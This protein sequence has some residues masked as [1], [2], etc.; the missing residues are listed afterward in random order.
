MAFF[1]TW[2]IHPNFQWLPVHHPEGIIQLL[3]TLLALPRVLLLK[4]Q[5]VIFQNALN[6]NNR[7]H[8]VL[9]KHNSRL[10]DILSELF[11]IF[12]IE[13]LL[14]GGL[15]AATV[16]STLPSTEK[17]RLY[18]VVAAL[19]EGLEDKSPLMKDARW[20]L[21]L[22]DINNGD[23][24]WKTM[25]EAWLG[26]IKQAFADGAAAAD[27]DLVAGDAGAGAGGAGDGIGDNALETRGPLSADERESA[28]CLLYALHGGS[29]ELL[30]A[31]EKGA[32]P[33]YLLQQSVGELVKW[34]TR[35]YSLGVVK[36]AM[37]ILFKLPWSW[38]VPV[39]VARV[40]RLQC[41]E[42]EK[43]WQLERLLSGWDPYTKTRIEGI[44]EEG[45]KHLDS[46]A[47]VIVAAV[48]RGDKEQVRQ[49]EGDPLFSILLKLSQ[50]ALTRI[51]KEVL[52]P[53]A[54]DKYKHN[55]SDNW[56]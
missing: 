52:I 10:V 4:H 36:T 32:L 25:N 27:T 49:G 11:H 40:T 23:E 14:L 12:P 6:E 55:G 1:E 9:L 7:G 48:L 16:P 41:D 15:Q 22:L 37:K 51:I 35:S 34:V 13:Q 42:G 31:F 19:L 47:D 53:A 26:L 50:S 54:T 21:F 28:G 20:L 5:P 43:V 44:E 8:L 46:H 30:Y 29:E 45:Q 39:V 18:R 17:L 3:E 24:E 38:V 2:R 56:Q 33:H